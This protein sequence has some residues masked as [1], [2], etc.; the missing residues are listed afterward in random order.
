MSDVEEYRC[1]IG[2]LSWST[3]DESLK[4]AFGK[5]GNL[6]EAKVVLENFLAAL[7]VSAL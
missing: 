5:F 6:T 2:D 1:F 3:T 7:V 4:D